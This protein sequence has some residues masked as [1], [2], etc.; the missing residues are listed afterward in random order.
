MF[1]NSVKCGCLCLDRCYDSAATVTRCVAW[2]G[3]GWSLFTM[4]FS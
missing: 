3:R 2:V 1:D 4:H